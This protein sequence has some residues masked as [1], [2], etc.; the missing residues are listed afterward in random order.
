[1]SHPGPLLTDYVDDMLAP[2][3]CAEVDAHLDGCATC[4]EEV[5]LARVGKRASGGLA[6]PVVPAG[7]AVRAIAEAAR[8]AT[9]RNPEVVPIPSGDRRRPNAPRWLAVVAAAAVVVAIAL[10][11]PKLGQAPS[12]VAE[13]A[14]PAAGA[15]GTTYPRPS[16]VEIQHA[17]YTFEGLSKGA[18]QL[19]AALTS[20]SEA[21]QDGAAAA[22]ATTTPTT[23]FTLGDNSN[24]F[25]YSADR[26]G[27]ATDCL[28][29]AFNYPEG[30]LVRI[31]LAKY[32][33]QKAYFAVYLTGPGAGLPSDE[34]RID[35]S[36]AH[37]CQI[38]A[39]SSAKL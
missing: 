35:V 3:V 25:E 12:S 36:S 16:A 32:Q 37:G 22:P 39:Q 31:I 2:E 10:I 13:Q 30:S 7:L 15:A 1:M 26:L 18:Q 28:D 23:G 24:A 20:G 33:G 19:Q 27:A 5:R 17:N 11:G 9:E 14:A 6:E 8:I 38:L 21:A 29:R 34:L 4:R